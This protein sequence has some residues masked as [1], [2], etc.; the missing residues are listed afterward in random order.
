MVK[1]SY[2]RIDLPKAPLP[3]D[4][5]C[6]TCLKISL[7]PPPLLKF[8]FISSVLKLL[9]CEQLILSG[10]CQKQSAEIV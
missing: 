2:I 8:D 3:E 6:L 7:K 1:Y 9:L 4:C 10:A 5:H